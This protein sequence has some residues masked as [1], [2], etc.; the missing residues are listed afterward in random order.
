MIR[1][2]KDVSPDIRKAFKNTFHTDLANFWDFTGFD[3]IKFDE[4]F[5]KPPDGKSTADVVREQYGDSAVELIYGLLGRIE[6]NT[7][8]EYPEVVVDKYYIGVYNGTV[9]LEYLETK[10]TRL[11]FHGLEFFLAHPL[12]DKKQINRRW[13]LFEAKSGAAILSVIDAT[14]KEGCLNKALEVLNSVDNPANW[15]GNLINK[16][17]DK[18][19]ISPRYRRIS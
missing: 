10:G 8:V 4:D 6:T 19:G 5:I 7:K 9:D 12:V 16:F 13:A 15:Y 1:P 2:L 18:W 11:E 17:T 14:G 3:V